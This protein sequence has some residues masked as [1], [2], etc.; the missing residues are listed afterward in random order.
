MPAKRDQQLLIDAAR[1]YY[2]DGLDQ[3]QVGARLGLSRSSVSRILHEARST[4]LVQ[5]RIVGDDRT[6]RN[7]DLER[8]LGQ[9][10]GLREA[11]VADTSA[12]TDH[13]ASVA[14]LAGE[15]FA[16]LASGSSRIGF[17][18]GLTIAQ[19]I[20]LLAET[21]LRSDTRIVPLVGGMPTLDS[22]PSG[23]THL[24][25]LADKCGATAG[26]FDA[27][28][29]VES[30]LTQQAM[31]S[32][33]SVQASL[34]EARSC[35]LGFVG[36]GNY[37]VQT[38]RAVMGAMKLSASEKSA[39]EA[40]HP[41][42]DMLGRY[43]TIEGVPLGPPTSERVIGID[44]D[45]LRRIETVVGLASGRAKAPGTLGALRTEALDIL[46]V[47]DVLAEALLAMAA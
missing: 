7:G 47:D 15:S 3:G 1:L 43:F 4:G 18:W 30:A 39:V 41:V 12:S 40:A 31:M 27:P 26:R 28:A 36:I 25:I 24:Q 42:G 5:I 13:L 23:N 14:R 19:F 32:E 20:D 38:S 29:I 34:A 33:S 11:L 10:F 21:P 6:V 37:E 46:V 45:D 2:V 44:L 16:R 9:A 8:R 35:D 17:G 22:A